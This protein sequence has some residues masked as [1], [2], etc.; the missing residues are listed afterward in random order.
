MK[1]MHSTRTPG[2]I[3]VVTCN[4]GENAADHSKKKREKKRR[5]RKMAQNKEHHAACMH[6]QQLAH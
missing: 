2:W 3:P 4:Q 1:F 5:E 6:N